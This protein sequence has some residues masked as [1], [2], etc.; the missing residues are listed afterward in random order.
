MRL[1]WLDL[2]DADGRKVSWLARREAFDG[3]DTGALNHLAVMVLI[4]LR[5]CGAT[6]QGG[7]WAVASR[8]CNEEARAVLKTRP[9][10][11]FMA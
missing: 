3:L 10:F 2:A 1:A 6:G 5:V 11:E 9:A 4:D 7:I 8:I